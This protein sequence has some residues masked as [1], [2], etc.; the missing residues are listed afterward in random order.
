MRIRNPLSPIEPPTCFVVMKPDFLSK[1]VQEGQILQTSDVR[2]NSYPTWNYRSPNFTL[3][4][5]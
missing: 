2:S 4:L 3:P 5:N 1:E